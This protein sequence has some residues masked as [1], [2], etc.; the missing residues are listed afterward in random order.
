MCGN[1]GYCHT[2]SFPSVVRPHEDL[3]GCRVGHTGQ[4]LG[5]VGLWEQTLPV[6]ENLQMHTH[7]HIGYIRGAS[8]CV[9]ARGLLMLSFGVPGGY[10]N[11]YMSLHHRLSL[12][13]QQREED[14]GDKHEKRGKKYT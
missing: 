8:V 6:A 9:R 7:T 14:Q 1:G 3:Q 4:Q 5:Q 2:S 13:C 11:D 10:S 12:Q